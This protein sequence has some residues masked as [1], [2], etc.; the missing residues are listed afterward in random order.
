MAD[1]EIVFETHATTIDNE[2]GIA[3]GWLPGELSEAGRRQASE[4]GARRRDDGIDLVVTSDLARAA[5]TVEIAFY[6]TTITVAADERLRECDYGGLNGAPV[7]QVHDV[8]M[9][10]LD[11]PYPGGESW[12]QATARVADFVSELAERPVDRVLVVGHMATRWGLA[13]L[14]DSVALEQLAGERF[15]WLPGWE[16]RLPR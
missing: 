4:L 12:R 9:A 16:F 13:H 8:R 14:L 3:T 5:D 15:V 7:D 11:I 2:V 6:Q 10:H 1:I